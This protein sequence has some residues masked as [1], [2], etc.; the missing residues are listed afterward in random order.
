M[1]LVKLEINLK[2][3]IHVS[4]ARY[5]IYGSYRLQKYLNSQVFIVL[6]SINIQ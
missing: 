6:V 1:V 5:R 3:Y 4:A 2:M